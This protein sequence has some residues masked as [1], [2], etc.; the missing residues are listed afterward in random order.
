VGL[1][2]LEF[3]SLVFEEGL[4]FEALVSETPRIR[5]VV[6]EALGLRRSWAL[7]WASSCWA[8]MR[9]IHGPTVTPN[10]LVWR[11]MKI[12]VFCE[13]WIKLSKLT[14]I[15]GIRRLSRL[16]SLACMRGLV[17]RERKTFEF[18]QVHLSGKIF[19]ISY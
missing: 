6:S 18:R 7:T 5:G 14:S 15:P 9:L 16:A 17:G 11:T 8:H 2:G 3:E 1:G 13:E 10:F 12:S 19:E 4:R